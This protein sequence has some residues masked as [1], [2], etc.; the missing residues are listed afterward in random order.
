[1]PDNLNEIP[2]GLA[3]NY[4]QEDDARY[5]VSLSTNVGIGRIHFLDEDSRRNNLIHLVVAA[6]DETDHYVDG[7]EKS[8]DFKLTDSSY[9]SLLNDGINSQATFRMPRGRYKI[10]AV[11][12]EGAQ[13]TMGSITKAT[14]IP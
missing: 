14:E 3:Y 11:V 1:M 10:K 2:I 5:S 6:F 12:R 7:V 8:I 9:A 4:Y 13:G